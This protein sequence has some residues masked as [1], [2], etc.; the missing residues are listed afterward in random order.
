M[1]PRQD[2]DQVIG[3]GFYPTSLCRLRATINGPKVPPTPDRVG[4]N[5][6]SAHV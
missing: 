5:R 3:H 2:R 6:G 4:L 1:E